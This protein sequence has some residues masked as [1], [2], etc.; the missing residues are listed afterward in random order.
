[1]IFFAEITKFFEKMLTRKNYFC[2]IHLTMETMST[3][4]VCS[5]C[6][7]FSNRKGVNGMAEKK[8]KEKKYVNSVLAWSLL[9]AEALIIVI[10]CLIVFM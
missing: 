9:G 8:G 1:M 3:R 4:V 6:T 10:I 5:L 7:L 2:K